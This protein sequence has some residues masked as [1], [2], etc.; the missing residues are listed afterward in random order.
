MSAQRGPHTPRPGFPSSAHV[1]PATD[2]HRI[3]ATRT[4]EERRLQRRTRPVNGA[5]PPFG[6]HHS[7]PVAGACGSGRPGRDQPDPNPGLRAAT[8][9]GP[10]DQVDE[11]HAAP[12]QRLIMYRVTRA[13]SAG[14]CDQRAT[15]PNPSRAAD[16]QGLVSSCMELTYRAAER[17]ADDAPSRRRIRNRNGHLH[18]HGRR[19]HRQ[20][21]DGHRHR[22]RSEPIWTGLAW[23]ARHVVCRRSAASSL[24]H[25]WG[26]SALAGTELVMSRPAS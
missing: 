20:V 15:F 5:D 17:A 2:R 21:R 9:T 25:P 23:S 3:P 8:S 26:A 12:H 24:S 1:V 18:R 13:R 16:E 6:V 22:H 10:T 11:G 4:E 19:R 14:Q 7:G